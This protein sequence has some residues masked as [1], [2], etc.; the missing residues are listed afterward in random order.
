MPVRAFISNIAPGWPA[1]RQ[2][3][4]LAEH[5]PGW[6]NVTVYRDILDARAR[7]AH[8]DA[9]MADRA[10]MLRPTG[11]PRAGEVIYVASLAVL[12]RGKDEFARVEAD[13]KRRGATFIALDGHETFA[14]A[15][16]E[17]GP[18]APSPAN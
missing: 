17:A 6:P 4:L 18:P 8:L 12:A 5:V 16:I 11:R 14:K 15:R 9:D 7:R 2:E 1:E 3:A 13:A 10:V